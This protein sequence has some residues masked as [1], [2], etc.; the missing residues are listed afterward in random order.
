MDDPDRMLARLDGSPPDYRDL[1]YEWEQ[2]RWESEKISLDADAPALA[3]VGK[4]ERAALES[5]VRIVAAVGDALSDPLVGVADAVPNEEQQV[6]VTTQLADL[7][8]QSVLFE[9]M[10]E[11]LFSVRGNGARPALPEGFDNLLNDELAGDGLTLLGDLDDR[12]AL[13]RVVVTAHLVLAGVVVPSLLGAALS[14]PA[15]AGLGGIRRGL[16]LCLRDYVR[17][18]LFGTRLL[19]EAMFDRATV[20]G[21]ARRA[22]G[23]ALMV[24]HDAE[25]KGH[26][27]ALGAT[28][29]WSVEAERTLERRLALLPQHLA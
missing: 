27:E 14:T 10:R 5:V 3:T 6:F 19:S 23:P 16:A 18:A 20:E 28:P 13:T 7:A 1:Y 12:G 25:A 26:A 2:E 9:R 21:H 24:L 15:L 4:D 29:G 17:H 8:R 22:A 11:S